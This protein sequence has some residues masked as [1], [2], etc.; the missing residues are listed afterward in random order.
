VTKKG[1]TEEWKKNKHGIR[2]K[3][4]KERRK[5]EIKNMSGTKNKKNGT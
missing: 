2:K 3:G 1:T 4:R 5:K